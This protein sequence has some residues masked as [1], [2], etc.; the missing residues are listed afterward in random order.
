MEK[1]LR[2]PNIHFY[3]LVKV[4][5]WRNVCS[6]LSVRVS[7]SGQPVNCSR[8]CFTNKPCDNLHNC[9]PELSTLHHT[10]LHT[11]TVKHTKLFCA[12]LSIAPKNIV[13]DNPV[14]IYTTTP[15]HTS[16]VIIHFY[17]WKHLR[18][19]FIWFGNR[20]HQVGSFTPWSNHKQVDSNTN[21]KFLWL[22]TR[23]ECYLVTRRIYYWYSKLITLKVILN[24]FFCAHTFSTLLH[25]LYISSRDFV[26]C[27]LLIYTFSS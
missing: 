19:S 15:T 20:F 16:H 18:T 10:I 22:C 7:N 17:I 13:Q 4:N 9:I 25:S 1:R 2:V 27:L 8:K 26:N 3:I 11:H 14:T 23:W 6:S 21:Y 24:I 12:T 5:I